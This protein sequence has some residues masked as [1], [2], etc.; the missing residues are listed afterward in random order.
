M[1]MALYRKI[2]DDAAQQGFTSVNLSGYNEPLLD[3]LLFDRVEYARQK[4]LSVGFYSNGTLLTEENI[5]KIVESGLDNIHFSF[6]GATKECYERARPNADFNHTKNGILRLIQYRRDVGAEKPHIG[7]EAA[8][9]ILNYRGLDSLRKL[10]RDAD[11]VTVRPADSRAGDTESLLLKQ[12]TKAYPYPCP[13]LWREFTVMSSGKVCLCCRDY[14]GSV[15][16]GD[17]NYQTIAEIW[18]SQRFKEIRELHLNGQGNAIKL[19]QHCRLIRL[20][21]AFSWWF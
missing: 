13:E 9:D 16:L 8:A 7:V 2:I 12:S 4:G 15:E 3:T 1:N 20:S 17:L 19:C 5:R 11:K 18:E 6:D 21:N 14:D 10:F